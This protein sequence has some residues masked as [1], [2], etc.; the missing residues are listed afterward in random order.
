MLSSMT[1]AQREKGRQTAFRQF[2]RTIEDGAR[3]PKDEVGRK[4]G[5]LLALGHERENLF[6]A[7]RGEG[8]ALA[9]FRE[10]GIPWWRANVSGDCS[11]REVP[12]RN[13]A[14]SQVC[15]ANF[16]LP[17]RHHPAA[18]TALLRSIDPD[19]IGVEA[20]PHQGRTSLVEL[21][22]VGMERTLEGGAYQRGANATS[23]DAFVL[24]RTEQ[25]LRAYL[26]EWKYVETSGDEPKGGDADA[27]GTRSRRYAEMFA[28]S[29]LFRVP[30]DV[31]M[32]EPFYQ[33]MRFHLLGWRTA[34]GEIPGV[35]DFRVVV[36]CPERNDAYRKLAPSHRARFPGATTVEEAMSERLL[37]SPS[38]FCMTSQSSLLDGV[39]ALASPELHD[40]ASYLRS[41]YAF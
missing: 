28:D 12:T 30:F 37:A 14:S 4:H 19:V 26:F 27:N 3:Q 39:D 9:Y 32:F 35:R 1:F 22:W 7:L 38:A 17:L 29:K 33:L 11:D 34:A 24:G 15:C 21:E 40:W 25:G 23:A 16:M 6:P 13:M 18:L 31:C 20:I 5:H 41:R 10:R 36:V 8:G 2:S